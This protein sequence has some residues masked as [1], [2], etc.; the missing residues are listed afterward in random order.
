LLLKNL[1]NVA[2]Y[3]VMYLLPFSVCECHLPSKRMT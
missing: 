1:P 2:I 3:F